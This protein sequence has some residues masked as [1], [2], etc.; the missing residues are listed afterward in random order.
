MSLTR[1]EI[2]AVS[3]RRKKK[4]SITLDDDVVEW[5]RTFSNVSSA[6][7]TVLREAMNA[8]GESIHPNSPKHSK[9]PA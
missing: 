7:N 5:L 6:A 3:S 9:E 2:E 1:E 4:M 8:I